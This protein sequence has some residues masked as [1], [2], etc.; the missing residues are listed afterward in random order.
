MPF[1]S[2]IRWEHSVRTFGENMPTDCKQVALKSLKF[3]T[4]LL[5]VALAEG[6]PTE[7]GRLLTVI[8]TEYYSVRIVHCELL[9]QSVNDI[10]LH[11]ELG[12]CWIDSR[13]T[14]R[15]TSTV[16]DCG[17]LLQH[18]VLRLSP[19]LDSS[20]FEVFYSVAFTVPHGSLSAERYHMSHLNV[21]HLPS[22]P[23]SYSNSY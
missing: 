3:Q 14:S 1:T 6:C 18:P 23:Y 4:S 16:T 12:R 7:L 11:S 9:C 13:V 5:S 17:V 21:P 15:V 10:H 22:P 19:A 2:C 20:S 8:F